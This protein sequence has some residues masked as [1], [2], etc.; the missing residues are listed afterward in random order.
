ME[1]ASMLAGER[2]SDHPRCVSPVVAA[3]VRVYNDLVDDRRRHD[4]YQYAA[5]AVGSRS[6]ASSERS[7]AQR[8]LDWMKAQLGD[9]SGLDVRLLE[10]G[11][12]TPRKRQVIAERVARYAASSR[13]RHADALRLLD[14]LVGVARDSLPVS[15]GGHAH[16]DE[17]ALAPVGV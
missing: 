8:C 12:R 13:S 6:G 7:R 3:F 2:F 1:L 14:E 9:R 10:L 5:A 17:P 16:A 4:L 15:A 11:P